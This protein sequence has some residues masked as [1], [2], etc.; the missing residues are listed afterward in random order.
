M[1]RFELLAPAGDLE[2]LN[3]ALRFGAD[4]VYAGGPKLQL[5][6]DAVGFTMDTLKT[7]ADTLH[8][9]GKKLFHQTVSS[10][11]C[12]LVLRIQHHNI[13]YALELS[14]AVC[15]NFMLGCGEKW[16]SGQKGNWLLLFPGF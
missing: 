14:K 11:A 8:A 9:A 4:A 10:F 7:A 1:S 6:A 15:V 13:Q 16:R 3:T 5:R 12:V 2:R